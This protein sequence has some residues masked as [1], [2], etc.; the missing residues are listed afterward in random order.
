MRKE[1]DFRIEKQFTLEKSKDSFVSCI[2]YNI[3]CGNIIMQKLDFLSSDVSFTHESAY[4]GKSKN[5][6]NAYYIVI[7]KYIRNW[8]DSFGTPLIEDESYVLFNGEIF[9]KVRKQ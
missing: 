5:Y 7:K 6:R 8:E 3:K 1:I 4:T 9:R 2:F